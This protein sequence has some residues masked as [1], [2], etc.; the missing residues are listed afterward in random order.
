MQP[1]TQPANHAATAVV[2]P[3][4]RPSTGEALAAVEATVLEDIAS[5][6]RRARD[7]QERW[8]ASPIARRVKAV[9]QVKTRILARAEEIAKL[10]HDE[11][12]KPDV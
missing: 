5:V 11:T 9:S 4:K 7:A 10:V 3:I 2:F 1:E 8:A 6:V 12:G